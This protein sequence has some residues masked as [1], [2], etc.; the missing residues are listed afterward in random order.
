M[1]TQETPIIAYH[2]ALLPI[3][4]SFVIAVATRLC[5]PRAPQLSTLLKAFTL[6]WTGTII[7]VTAVVNFSLS[8][9]IAVLL[10]VPLCIIPVNGANHRLRG[11]FRTVSTLLLLAITPQGICLISSQLLGSQQATDWFVG[12]V[13]EWDI[14]ASTFLPFI[15]A[16]YMPL[17]MQGI[18]A[19]LL[20][21]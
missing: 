16:G 12:T 15:C 20:M 6:C 19:C 1:V 7:A 9:A 5:L 18:I 10:G 11:A 14:V 2:V 4:S 21:R 8:A 13:K 17:I 3:L